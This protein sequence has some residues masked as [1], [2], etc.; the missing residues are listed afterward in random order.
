MP[1]AGKAGRPA[2][3]EPGGAVRD[4]VEGL[5]HA[6]NHLEV[7]RSLGRVQAEDST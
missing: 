5:P 3:D 7:C 4:E 1:L 6:R 2:G